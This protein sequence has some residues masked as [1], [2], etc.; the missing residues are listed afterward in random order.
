M[1]FVYS[2]R[3]FVIS[4][5]GRAGEL[6]RRCFSSSAE[7]THFASPAAALTACRSLVG[8]TTTR[9][10]SGGGGACGVPDLVIIELCNGSESWVPMLHAMTEIK[11][12]PSR[13][14][15]VEPGM[16]DE[17][18]FETFREGQDHLL[19]WPCSADEL[20]SVVGHMTHHAH[21]TPVANPT[22]MFHS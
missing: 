8:G 1:V 16:L 6:A 13:L 12:A 20:M 3:V 7:L 11:C 17:V 15:L 4:Q 18:M 9:A 5:T 14:L 22:R 10:V 2:R 19:L 21:Q